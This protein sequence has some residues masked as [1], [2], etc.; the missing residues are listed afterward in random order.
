VQYREAHVPQ[1]NQEQLFF[2]DP[3]GNGVEL[4]FPMGAAAE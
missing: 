1:S 3:A 4:I 2:R